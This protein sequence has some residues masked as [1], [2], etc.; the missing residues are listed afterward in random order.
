VIQQ[1]N[2]KPPAEGGWNLFATY[3]ILAT[4]GDPFGNTTLSAAGRKSWAGWPDVPEIE[5]LRLDFAAATTSE[6]QKAIA[7]KIQKLA[8][9]E[10][11]VGPLGQFRIPSA[12]SAKLSGVLE[13]PVTAF[14]NMSKP[15]E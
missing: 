9:D 14:W 12:Y 2:Q 3:S 5:K 4:S 13:S 7:A 11:V 15:G 1:G 10:G 8:I 6:G